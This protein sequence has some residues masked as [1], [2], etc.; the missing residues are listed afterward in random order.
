MLYVMYLSRGPAEVH[1]L[2][3]IL[4]ITSVNMEQ[5]QIWGTFWFDTPPL[6]VFASDKDG[7]WSNVPVSSRCRETVG[8]RE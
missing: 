4:Y 6:A 3:E 1:L 7:I 5:Y 2:T 8:R